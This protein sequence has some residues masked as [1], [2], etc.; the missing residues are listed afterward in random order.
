MKRVGGDVMNN[1][2]DKIIQQ[3]L[4]HINKYKVENI[5]PLIK[6]YSNDA[7]YLLQLNNGMSILMKV[8]NMKDYNRKKQEFN[9]LKVHYNNGVK[10]SEPL[11]F[12]VIEE[13]NVCITVL[14]Y[15]E[16]KSADEVLPLL[17]KEMQYS[18]GYKAANELR[19]IHEVKPSES[20]NWYKKRWEKYGLKKKQLF[21]LGCSFYKQDEI[22]NYIKENFEILRESTVRFQHDDFQPMNIIINEKEL[23]GIIDFN[24]YDWG[25]PMEDF[26][27]LPKYTNEISV[28]FSKGQVDGYFDGNVPTWFWKKYNLFV[29][30]NFHASMIGGYEYNQL[31]KVRERQIKIY[32][33]HDFATHGAPAW[34]LK[35]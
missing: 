31:D 4:L 13:L 5:K 20:F 3:A 8:S 10:C 30:L 25:D 27:K 23:I 28:Q 29:A 21:E 1:I 19:K 14:T 9:Y 18:L 6:G 2:Q 7:K 24:R 17:A 22:E 32:N 12:F 34:Y 15:L 26:F 11:D 16:G 33:T 35:D